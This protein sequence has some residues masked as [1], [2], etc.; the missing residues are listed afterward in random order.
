VIGRHGFTHAAA[1]EAALVL[2]NALFSARARASY[3]VLP[4]TTFTDPEIAHVGLTEE[5][6]RARHGDGVRVYR[7][8]FAEVDR[9]IVERRTRGVVKLVTAGRLDR[10]VGAQIAGPAAGELIHEFALAMRQGLRAGELAQ[11][12]HVYTTLALGAQH[13]ALAPPSDGW[14]ASLAAAGSR[15]PLALAPAHAPPL[16]IGARPPPHGHR[17]PLSRAHLSVRRPGPRPAGTYTRRWSAR[18]RAPHSP[19]RG[20][21]APGGR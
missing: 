6:A 3:E 5:Q 17:A 12:V 11:M 18:W 10:V 14:T 7:Y 8:P 2:R 15:L 19:A 9:A 4:R 13:A 1:Y 16:A 20:A 21:G